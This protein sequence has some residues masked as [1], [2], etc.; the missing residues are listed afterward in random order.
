MIPG[1]KEIHN[2]EEL[3][4]K[5]LEK[6]SLMDIDTLITD[7]KFKLIQENIN[8]TVPIYFDNIDNNSLSQIKTLCIVN[9]LSYL[10]N[11]DED[12]D[13]KGKLCMYIC[14]AIV[15]TIYNLLT[16]EKV[17]VWN[18]IFDTGEKLVSKKIFLD[19]KI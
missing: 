7:N 4:E 14:D 11:M 15:Y 17:I 3:R 18:I 13:I 16:V 19:L 2:L 10:N 1:L 6:E 12:I 8:S 9:I 5:T